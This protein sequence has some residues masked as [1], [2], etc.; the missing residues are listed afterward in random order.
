MRIKIRNA[1]ELILMCI[2]LAGELPKNFDPAEYNIPIT[3]A[4]LKTRITAMK[5]NGLVTSRRK[6]NYTRLKDPEG[7]KALANF[8][9][10]LFEHYMRISNNHSSGRSGSAKKKMNISAQVSSVF[11][12]MRCGCLIDTIGMEYDS[13]LFG[14]KNKNENNVLDSIL[15]GSDFFINNTA[16]PT[17][18]LD[19]KGEILPLRKLAESANHKEPCFFSARFIKNSIETRESKIKIRGSRFTGFFLNDSDIFS[20][21]YIDKAD[22]DFLIK[23]NAEAEAKITGAKIF[24]AA[25]PD[26]QILTVPD[27]III[28]PDKELIP[29][30]INP[31]KRKRFSLNSIYNS[32]SIIPD[33]EEGQFMMEIFKTKNYREKIKNTLYY[34][35]EIRNDKDCDGIIDGRKSWELITCN[36][37]KI[38]RI[39]KEKTRKAHVICFDTQE[40]MIKELLKGYN[41][42]FITI[43]WEDR[44]ELKRLMKEQ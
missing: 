41:T 6:Q 2:A 25:N 11:F 20:V 22:E 32:F 44:H 27:S 43:K 34:P 16:S 26:K 37:S 14:K 1:Q 9:E 42:E 35:E 30:I 13:N 19:S 15:G 36:Y 40:E 18:F 28:I 21:Y 10:A 33:D 17:F 12:M 8:S 5:K 23:N 3:K 24:N 39:K 7:L 38:Y 31:E 29:S 4:Y